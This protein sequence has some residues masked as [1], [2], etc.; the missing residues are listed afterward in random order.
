M[1]SQTNDFTNCIAENKIIQKNW[2]LPRIKRNFN[3]LF[4]L[5]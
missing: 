2:D 4:D 1:I 5:N 3:K